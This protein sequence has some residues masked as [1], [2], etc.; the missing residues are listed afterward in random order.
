MLSLGQYIMKKGYSGTSSFLTTN[1]NQIAAFINDESVIDF[2]D[3]NPGVST[4]EIKNSVYK[5]WF[6]VRNR[7]KMTGFE[8]LSEL[9]KNHRTRLQKLYGQ[10]DAPVEKWY[11]S[12]DIPPSDDMN[13][14]FLEACIEAA[15][16]HKQRADQANRKIY[17][18]MSGGLDSEI[19]A[20]SFKL[21]EIEFTPFI[22]DYKGRND[23]D[24]AYAIVWCAE[25][26]ITPV[27]HVLDL[28]TFFETEMYEYAQETGVTSPQILTYQKVIDIVCKEKDAYVVM[29]GEIRAYA[30][31]NKDVVGSYA[32]DKHETHF[33]GFFSYQE[34]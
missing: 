20:L 11:G 1:P 18:C 26:K 13:T 23:F 9:D 8:N 21:A 17:V 33:F 7:K 30:N 29:G 2:L 6:K 19:T 4:N 24:T 32:W 15:H 3:K 10:D 27:V 31:Q 28:E 14:N 12:L 25:N 16:Y 34:K 22:V 5:K